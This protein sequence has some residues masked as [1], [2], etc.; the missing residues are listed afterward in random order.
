MPSVAPSRR[1][2]HAAD[3]YGFELVEE[4]AL[5]RLE[6]F[7]TSDTLQVLELGLKGRHLALTRAALS[8]L[9]GDFSSE[10]PTTWARM[11]PSGGN[12]FGYAISG[13]PIRL[14]SLSNEV[15]ATLP[16]KTIKTLFN[17]E[18]QVILHGKTWSSLASSFVSLPCLLVAVSDNGPHTLEAERMPSLLPRPLRDGLQSS[19]V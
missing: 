9:G 7:A 8:C 17:L 14:V 2:Y 18:G 12:R 1:L 19:T 16:I 4:A 13:S 6:N 10:G 5:A 3:K 15:L 11:T